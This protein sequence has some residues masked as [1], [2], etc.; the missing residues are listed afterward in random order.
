M[1]ILA[2]LVLVLFISVAGVS[3]QA[4]LHGRGESGAYSRS[5][6]RVSPLLELQAAWL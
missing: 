6:T 4:P 5:A 1:K 2:L 3:A